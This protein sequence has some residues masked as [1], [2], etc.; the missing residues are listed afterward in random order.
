[1][2]AVRSREPAGTRLRVIPGPQDDAF[3][4]AAFGTLQRARY[5]VSPQSDRM[6]YR[7]TGESIAPQSGRS[8]GPGA[9]RVVASEGASGA[10]ISDAAFT[11][12]IQVP[13]SG[14]PIILMADRQT[15]GGYPQIATVISADLPAA[16]QLAPGDWVEFALCTRAEAIA[17]LV[18][19]KDA[20]R[21]LG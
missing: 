9:A 5:V 15:T 3:D 4:E 11:G 20:L 19:Q 17:A 10:M 13:P 18:A 2:A 1:A 12:G 21:G 16:G 8:G 7:L 6:G 14:N